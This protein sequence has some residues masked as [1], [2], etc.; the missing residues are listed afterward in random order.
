MAFTR[1]GADEYRALDLEALRARQ[2]S[3]A[4]ELENED[5]ELSTDELIEERDLCLDAIRRREA[6]VEMRNGAA[7]EVRSGMG[8]VLG[9][10]GRGRV[11]TVRAEDPYATDEYMRAFAEYV[12]RG[13]K[14]PKDY[15]PE[16]PEMRADAVTTVGTDATAVVPTQLQ[17]RIIM[18]EE[19]YGTILN[20]VTKTTYP[21]GVNIPK[22]DSKPTASWITETKVSDTQK[23]TSTDYVSFGYHGLEVRLAQ[24]ELASAITLSAFQ[25]KFVETAAE[26]MVKAK[27][28]GIISGTGSGQM[29]GVTADT[30]VTNKQTMAATDVAGWAGWH[31]T[32]KANIPLAY[33]TGSLIMNVATWEQYV[34]GMVDENGQPVARVNYG[35]NGEELHRFMGK[36]VIVVD[37]DLLPDYDTAA[38]TGAVFAVY[39]RLSDYMIN[40]P[41]PLRTERWHDPNDARDKV[42][43]VE[44][45]DGKL[46]DP[47]GVML[48]SAAKTGTGS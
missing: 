42:R 19:V 44:Y 9:S 13:R 16:I 2:A 29:L 10:S 26:A 21:G 28:K 25:D 47:Y 24:T 5:S 34:D 23:L 18:E 33:R 3:I 15:I 6:A 38:S 43:M 46:V 36:S 14:I 41:L 8:L 20:G 30:D 48:I 32:V 27:E 40:S 12:T 11:E 4:D 35:V 39:M 31:K 17:N 37:D 1:M 7:N 45:L 22:L